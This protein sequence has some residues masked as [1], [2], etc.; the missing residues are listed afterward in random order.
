MITTRMLM[1][2][3][4]ALV[5]AVLCMIHPTA[6][7]GAQG[8]GRRNGGGGYQQYFGSASDYYVPPDWNGNPAYEGRVTFVR[9]KYRGYEHFTN[10]GPGWAHD[11]PIAESH[12][13]R[14]MSSITSMRLFVAAPP[15]YGSTVLALDDPMLMKYPVAY[16]SEPG[17]WHMTPTEVAG[18]RK[19][20]SRGGFIIFDDM[21][22]CGRQFTDLPNL[23]LEWQKAFPNAK[24]MD[25]PQNHPMFDSFFKI[26][27]TKVQGYYGTPG[28]FAFYE[29]N[30]PK[31]R[32]LGVVNNMQDLGDWMEW[33]D[34]GFA[35]TPSNE[36][37]K[38]AVNYFVYA[39]TH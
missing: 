34:R 37:Y 38:L 30:D 20:I 28:F 25:L 19:Y 39:L 24:L 26:D 13:D 22:C 7:A 12:F 9:I 17:G 15:I 16:L 18:F 31:K 32:I 3:R 29:D 4:L 23:V 1:M 11:Y 2:A 5:V 36:A 33:S 8:G 35:V 6:H 10:Q 21:G 14:I 27:F